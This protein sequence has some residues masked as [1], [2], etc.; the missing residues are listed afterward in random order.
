M[1]TDFRLDAAF[2]FEKMPADL[3]FSSFCDGGEDDGIVTEVARRPILYDSTV[4]AVD[5]DNALDFCDAVKLERGARSFAFVGGDF[6][7]GDIFE[8][9]AALGVRF[10]SLTIQT[11]SISAENVDSLVNLTMMC[12]EIER[13][14]LV[15]STYF[16]AHE[17]YPGGIVPY[18]YRELEDAVPEFDVAFAMVHTKVASFETVDGLRVVADGSANMRSSKS[19]EQVR[20]E[21]DDGLYKFVE[22]FADKLFAA[23]SVINDGRVKPD[24]TRG[25][26]RKLWEMITDE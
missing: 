22:D 5:F 24:N 1:K 8:G 12:P 7:F 20:V 3:D 16:W 9:W 14:R 26:Q 21:C 19:I 6:I 15:L 11:L 17:H 10:K 13:I 4:R 2:G 25:G 23:Y 18:M